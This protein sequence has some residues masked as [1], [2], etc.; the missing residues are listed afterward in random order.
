[1]SQ[2][3]ALT[4]VRRDHVGLIAGYSMRFSLRTGG[5]LLTILAV[6]IGGL[7]VAGAFCAPIEELM[8]EAPGLGHSP[9][10]AAGT[11]DR[12]ARA[13]QVIHIV[14][15]ITGAEE[16]QVTYLLSDQPALLSAITIVL[17]MLFPFVACLGAFNQTSGDIGSRGLR[18]LL[19]RTE[20]PN[21]FLGRFA[22][23]LGFLT[24]STAAVYT[25]IAL[26]VG[27]KFNVYP[28]LDLLTWSIQGCLAILLLALPYVAMCAWMSALL[29]SAFGSLA[30]CLLLTGF[31][32]LFLKI[33]NASTRDAVPWIDRL[34]PWG[35]KYDLLSV[36]V[37][38]RLLA[39]AAMLGFTA[40][41]L[42]IGLKS[43]RRRDL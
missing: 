39:Y 24:L 22:G 6:L 35:W 13:P 27:L 9:G 32:I 18:Y 20:R 11:V 4:G 5:G 41:F 7:A 28:A 37:G 1:M 15:W 42:A 21:V 33:L 30:L 17:L 12:I 34:L 26:Y 16:R 23:T 3:T 2:D 31:P 38:R 29:D 14:E 8:K 10:E 36:D 43:F 19:L 25:L 40:F